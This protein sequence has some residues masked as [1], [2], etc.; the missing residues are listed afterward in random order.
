MK[1]LRAI[2]LVLVL[3][4][5]FMVIGAQDDMGMLRIGVA[6]PV[7]LD[8]H[9]GTNDSEILFNRQIYDYLV[10]I[11]P[12]GDLVPQLATEW[13]V[14]DDGLTYSMSLAEGV[15]FHDGSAF[16]SADV[17]YSFQRMQEVGS[18]SLNLLGEF[19]V[20]AD[21]DNGVTFTLASVNADFMFG[22]ASR[23]AYILKDGATDVNV[24]T[25]DMGNFN[26]TGPFV[27]AGYSEGEGAE[28]TANADYWI[29]GEP[30]VSGVN[31]VFIDEKQAQIDAFRAGSLDVVFRIPLDRIEELRGE[32][33]NVVSKATNLHPVIR[34]R[35]DEGFLG[36]DPRIMQAF[37]L[38]TDRE[39][40]VLDLFGEGVA[41]VG[42]NDPIGPK[43]GIFY[44]QIADE[45]D[46]EAACALLAEAGFPD[47]IGADEPL[48]FYVVDAFNYADMGVLLQDQWS[49]A[50]INV[51]LLV[52]PENV[53]YGDNEWIDVELGVTGWGDRPIA[54]QYLVEAYVTSA[55]PENGGFNES[56]WSDE[57]V[58]ALVADAAVTP[59]IDARA[60]IY[61]QIAGI[62]A[63]RGPV[64]IPFF[65]PT[66]GLFGE[67]VSG[68]DMHPFAG[69]S[70]LRTVTLGGM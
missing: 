28:L 24:L 64:I 16:T 9:L 29:E 10:D 57:E 8:P 13:T 7:Q 70:D 42:N 17:V 55:L 61:R 66:V 12:E 51:D 36:E 65:A 23:W 48:P 31:F 3:I 33:I 2:L 1:T 20:A 30:M 56:H 45:Y 11:N 14:S 22:V 50:C 43:Y 21:G 15:T 34:L 4:V 53:Y 38:A 63:E 59:A 25:G 40:L 39:L 26:G 37:K 47:G 52:R 62:F 6:A 46:P 44:E 35:S 58:D 49:Q 69:R 18:P 32:G 5:P 54:Q 41:T 27:L 67:D 19:E 68:L 60:E